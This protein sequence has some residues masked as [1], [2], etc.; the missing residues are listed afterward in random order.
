MY[1]RGVPHIVGKLSTRATMLFKT[2]SQLKVFTRSYG[3]SKCESLNFENFGTPDLGVLGK[4]TF[5][6]TLMTSH[7]RGGGRQQPHHNINQSSESTK[8]EENATQ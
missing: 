1:V 2:S 6:C 7:R 4:M 5:G 8:G 3:L